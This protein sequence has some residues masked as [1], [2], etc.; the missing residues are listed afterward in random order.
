MG[1]QLSW[2]LQDINQELLIYDNLGL[3]YY[4]LGNSKIAKAFHD[5]MVLGHPEDNVEFKKYGLSLYLQRMMNS[6]LEKKLDKTFMKA[7]ISH[8]DNEKR[9]LEFEE[10]PPINNHKLNVEL[11]KLELEGK[12]SRPE[13]KV[14]EFVFKNQSY[15]KKR[16]K[17]LLFEPTHS[18]LLLIII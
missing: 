11:K 16:E 6:A 13:K 3:I 5:K 17:Y 10:K 8:I 4:Y 9:H 18:K 1:L 15:F 2:K 12:I 7:F 14:G